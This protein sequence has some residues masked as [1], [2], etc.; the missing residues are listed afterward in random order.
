[1]TD[2]PVVPIGTKNLYFL[3]SFVFRSSAA[4]QAKLFENSLYSS[5]LGSKVLNK[6]KN[7]PMGRKWQ[8]VS[9]KGRPL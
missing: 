2:L 8:K 5:F 9:G 6:D 3:Y 1:M 4:P 7:I